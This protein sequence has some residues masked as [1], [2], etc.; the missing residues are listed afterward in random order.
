VS[1]PS[2]SLPRK[3]ASTSSFATAVTGSTFLPQVGRINEGGPVSTPATVSGVFSFASG[4]S[5]TGIGANLGKNN[6]PSMSA[7]PSL[8]EVERGRRKVTNLSLSQSLNWF[9]GS[10]VEESP[11]VPATPQLPELSSSE[12]IHMLSP[13]AVPSPQHARALSHMF[14]TKE[15]VLPFAVL[16][17]ILAS[18]CS[19]DSPSS[20]QVPGWDM[21][22]TYWKRASSNPSQNTYATSERMGHFSMLIAPCVWA[23]DVWEPRYKAMVALVETPDGSMGFE[24]DLML[25]LRS[26]IEGA[27]GRLVTSDMIPFDERLERERSVDVLSKFLISFLLDVKVASRLDQ[28]DIALLLESLEVMVGCALT[29]DPNRIYS[30]TLSQGPSTPSSTN[31]TPPRKSIPHQRRPSSHFVPLSSPTPIPV[32]VPLDCIIDVY[33]NFLTSQD[34][35][36]SYKHLET[37]IHILC[38]VLAYYNAPIPVPSASIDSQSHPTSPYYK[39]VVDAL[40]GLLSGPHSASVRLHLKKCLS[41][42]IAHKRDVPVAIQVSTGAF[43]IIRV[44]IRLALRE[45]LQLPSEV[46][47]S[48]QN[49]LLDDADMDPG[50]HA[51]KPSHFG[52]AFREALKAWVGATLHGSTCEPVLEEAVGIINDVLH[53]YDASELQG[54]ESDE[55][56]ALGESLL[57]IVKY[58]KRYRSVYMHLCQKVGF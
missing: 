8:V 20:C 46:P 49:E 37:T 15:L 7:H 39:H 4:S 26:W 19:S 35:K 3:R 51:F 57:E 28:A 50:A 48:T 38:R 29:L 30:P 54:L 34:T 55:S 5:S 10:K 27:F 56:V 14:A 1:S 31:H 52:R 6:R 13:P 2:S 32:K 12:L 23:M 53:V 47:R 11:P 21:M 40:S 17:P 43:R 45:R 18:L 36:L 41:P 33:V 16:Q 25:S 24:K 58:V 44:F 42:V 9:K 22:A